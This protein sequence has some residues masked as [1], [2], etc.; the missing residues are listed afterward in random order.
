V[1]PSRPRPHAGAY[2]RGLD[3]LESG[4]QLGHGPI[5]TPAGVGGT[6]PIGVFTDL[7]DRPRGV[8][9]ERVDKA[10]GCR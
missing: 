5:M 8:A 2:A 7:D 10:V 9:G 6:A 3:N 1:A 4:A